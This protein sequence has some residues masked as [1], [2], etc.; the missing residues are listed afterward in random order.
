MPHITVTGSDTGRQIK[1]ISIHAEVHFKQETFNS[2]ASKL[3]LEI[4]KEKLEHIIEEYYDHI[5]S[6]IH[7]NHEWNIRT[8]T[9]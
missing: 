9:F 5:E 2:P 4:L 8:M 7:S 6:E 3:K 1:L